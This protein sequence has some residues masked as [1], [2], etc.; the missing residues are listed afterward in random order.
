MVDPP[1][2]RKR[3]GFNDLAAGL[4]E[5]RVEYFTSKLDRV[6]RLIPERAEELHAISLIIRKRTSITITKTAIRERVQRSVRGCWSPT[7]S[8]PA[9]V[10]AFT[11][12]LHPDPLSCGFEVVRLPMKTVPTSVMAAS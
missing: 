12:R 11:A 5:H 2:T 4:A 10:C 3:S 6:L 1:R 8:V 9:A 7:A